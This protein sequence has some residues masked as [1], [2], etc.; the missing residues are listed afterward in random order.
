[1]FDFRWSDVQGE[2]DEDIANAN[3]IGSLK[4]Q[5]NQQIYQKK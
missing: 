2:V 4:K 3:F 1:M 5:D